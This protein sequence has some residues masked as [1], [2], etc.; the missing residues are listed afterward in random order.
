MFIEKATESVPE[1]GTDWCLVFC[2]LSA[3]LEIS[4]FAGKTS[5]LGVE[6]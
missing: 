4:A 5:N 2:G 1:W 3:R 6:G